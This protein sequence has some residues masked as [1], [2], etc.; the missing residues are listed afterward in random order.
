MDLLTHLTGYSYSI[1][2]K[3]TNKQKQVLTDSIKF[4]K[5]PENHSTNILI[6][7]FKNFVL[8][9]VVVVGVGGWYLK[10]TQ[11]TELNHSSS[12]N[13]DTGFNYFTKRYFPNVHCV[14][15]DISKRFTIRFTFGLQILNVF[16]LKAKMEE[17]EV[18]FCHLLFLYS[19]EVKIWV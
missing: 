11:K 8:V 10:K 7:D 13:Y 6:Y 3:V 19:R 2:Y 4:Q 15:G 9:V 14:K 16:I 5:A 12:S 17:N 1:T 18:H